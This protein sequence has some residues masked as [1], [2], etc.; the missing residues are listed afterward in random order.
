MFFEGIRSERKLIE[1]ASLNRARSWYL[2]G[3]MHERD[4]G[5]VADQEVVHRHEA[6][7]SPSGAGLWRHRLIEAIELGT[8]VARDGEPGLDGTRVLEPRSSGFMGLNLALVRW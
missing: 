7:C 1:T 8:V 3:G 5:T 6:S 4:N 2:G